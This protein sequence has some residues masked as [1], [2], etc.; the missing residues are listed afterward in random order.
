MASKSKASAPKAAKR[1][2]RSAAGENRSDNPMDW[3][4]DDP[5][6]DYPEFGFGI[7]RQT[8]RGFPNTPS[9]FGGRK[10]RPVCKDSKPA[11]R[12]DEITAS[13]A[14]VV[15]PPDA[16][17]L[18]ARPCAMLQALD[19]A[20]VPHEQAVLIYAT[21][22]YPDETREHHAWN[23]ARAFAFSVLALK[24]QLPTL[25]VL[26]NPAVVAS[27]NP[28]HVHLLISPRR[29]NGLGFKGFDGD[30]IHNEAQKL[31]F[32]EWRAFKRQ[33]RALYA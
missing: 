11:L 12:D 29:V 30:L 3:L 18:I 20:I 5:L 27:E 33:W 7:L 22:S 17:D 1:S 9:E 21:L 25:V 23:E 10:L 26:H 19:E 31:L 13:W 2:T 28:I 32:D 8:Y 14:D 6:G 24:R 4:F 15:L 16:P